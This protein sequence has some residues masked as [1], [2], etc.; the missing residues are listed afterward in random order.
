MTTELLHQAM[1]SLDLAQALLEKSSHHES[2]LATYKAIRTHLA[3]TA[4]EDFTHVAVVARTLMKFEICWLCEVPAGT[5]LY[6][7]LPAPPAPKE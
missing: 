3:T 6:A 1:E 4:P 2:I 7:K 5:Y